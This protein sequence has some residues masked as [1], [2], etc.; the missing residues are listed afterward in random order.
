MF[1]DTS[2]LEKFFYNL[3]IN[4][5]YELKIRYVHIDNNQ[6][7]NTWSLKC[8]SCT[9]EEQAIINVIKSN[10]MVKQEEIASETNKFLRTVKTYMSVMQ[11]K[12][13]IERINEKR[14]GK[15]I[16]KLKENI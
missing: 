1:E 3:L 10:L 14:N 7:A 13:L 8:N 4:A 12:G 5:K 2:F 9:L 15:W 16:A 11:E 6:S